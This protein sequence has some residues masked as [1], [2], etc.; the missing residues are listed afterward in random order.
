MNDIIYRLD[1]LQL[2][3][4]AFDNNWTVSDTMD[5]LENLPSAHPEHKVGR[6]I[7]EPYRER[8]WHCSKCGQ[9]VGMTKAFYNYCFNCGARMEGSDCT[10]TD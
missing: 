6:W 9:V 2:F 3:E 5:A 7:E 4:I 10:D 1:A 8:H